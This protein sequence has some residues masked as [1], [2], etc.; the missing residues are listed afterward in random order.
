MYKLIKRN[1]VSFNNN[2]F[3]LVYQNAIK[4]IKKTK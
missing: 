1:P 2:I 4:K 3:G